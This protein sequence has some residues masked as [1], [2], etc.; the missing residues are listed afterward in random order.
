MTS[1]AL[2][3]SR[4]PLPSVGVGLQ[5]REAPLR[6]TVGYAGSTTTTFPA[7]DVTM[8]Q[9]IEIYLEWPGL[10]PDGPEVSVEVTQDMGVMFAEVH[11]T[12]LTGVDGYLREEFQDEP[13][14]SWRILRGLVGPTIWAIVRDLARAGNDAE[15]EV[16]VNADDL[17][18]LTEVWA[19]VRE[20]GESNTL[21][22]MPDPEVARQMGIVFADP[23][24]AARVLDRMDRMFEELDREPGHN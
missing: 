3:A 15:I 8:P 22:P 11:P 1:V 19:S 2:L 18:P 13:T 23:T 16:D 20:L 21:R 10:D 6:V 24:L 5:G 7:G 17:V 14:G 4:S 9:S 12:R